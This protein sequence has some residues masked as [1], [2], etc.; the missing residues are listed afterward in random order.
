LARAQPLAAHVYAERG[1]VRHE[2]ASLL[3]TEL[4]PL[5]L[6]RIEAEGTGVALTLLNPSEETVE[7]RIGAGTFSP[8]SA[9]RT[10]LSG[11]TLEALPCESGTVRLSVAP[12]AWTR[13]ALKP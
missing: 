1:P 2:A 6:T 8:A 12:R 4:G 9:S 13:L 10:S 11:E 5:L 7:A 3:T